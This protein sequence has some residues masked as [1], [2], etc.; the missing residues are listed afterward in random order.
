[1]YLN[2]NVN[3]LIKYSMGSKVE[4]VQYYLPLLNYLNVMVSCRK[5]I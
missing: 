4:E 2:H 5:N 3:K 1:M